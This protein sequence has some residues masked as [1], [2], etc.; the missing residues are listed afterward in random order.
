MKH[1]SH[2]TLYWLL[3]PHPPTLNAKKRSTELC[4]L[5]TQSLTKCSVRDD[6]VV[7]GGEKSQVLANVLVRF[8]WDVLLEPGRTFKRIF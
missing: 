7:A 8:G 5:M 2:H 1:L 3:A 6:G 4:D